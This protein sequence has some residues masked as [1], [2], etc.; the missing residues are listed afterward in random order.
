MDISLIICIKYDFIDVRM[1]YLDSNNTF[2]VDESMELGD[3]ILFGT[4]NIVS[5]PK[6]YKLSQKVSVMMFSTC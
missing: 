5:V 6:L 1:I 2:G 3:F 4:E